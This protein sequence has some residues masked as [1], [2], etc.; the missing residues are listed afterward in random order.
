MNYINKDATDS[1]IR[2]GSLWITAIVGLLVYAAA[3]KPP[4]FLDMVKFIFLSVD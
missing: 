1:T 3:I 2:K 4:D